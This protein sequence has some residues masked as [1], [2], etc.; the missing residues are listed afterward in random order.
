M[1][2]LTLLNSKLIHIILI[3]IRSYSLVYLQWQNSA[4]PCYRRWSSRLTHHVKTVNPWNINAWS[5]QT[6]LNKMTVVI[7]IFTWLPLEFQTVEI[8][9]FFPLSWFVPGLPGYFFTSAH[10]QDSDSSY[11]AW[12]SHS[13]HV[14]RDSDWDSDFTW[15]TQLQL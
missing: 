10:N 4:S 15:R 12:D 14:T 2:F 6:H 13:N 8:N 1:T 11:T 9:F 3:L 7:H 5:C